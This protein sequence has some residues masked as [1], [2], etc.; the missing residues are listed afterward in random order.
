MKLL[1]T[2]RK[3]VE[4]DLTHLYK[5]QKIFDIS[6]KDSINFCNFVQINGW[7][8]G[9]NGNYF[10]FTITNVKI[11]NTPSQLYALYLTNTKQ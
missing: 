1:E 6:Q 7:N 9:I 3:L 4:A 8:L 5:S 11:E 2:Y 10:H